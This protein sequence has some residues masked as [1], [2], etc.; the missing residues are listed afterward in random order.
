V[1]KA[2][3]AFKVYSQAFSSKSECT[4]PGS[5]E[6]GVRKNFSVQNLGKIAQALGLSID[7]LARPL[8]IPD[9]IK[10]E[11]TMYHGGRCVTRL[12]GARPI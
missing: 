1:A 2:A 8:D 4:L 12:H 7:Q 5:S 10:S 6:C 9:D 3:L 11:S